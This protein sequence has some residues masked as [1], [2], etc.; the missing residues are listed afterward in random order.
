MET[1]ASQLSNNSLA[2][3]SKPLV[4]FSTD[5]SKDLDPRD[6]DK[7][8]NEMAAM[9]MRFTAFRRFICSNTEVRVHYKCFI[10]LS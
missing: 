5:H 2:S 8:L 10:Y 1:G 4:L 6:V 9:V 3:L 7:A